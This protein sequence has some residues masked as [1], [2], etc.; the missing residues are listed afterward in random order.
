MQNMIGPELNIDGFGNFGREIF[1][2]AYAYER[3]YEVAD[4]LSLVRSGHTWRLGGLYQ[5]VQ[6]VTDT[7][8]YFG[9]RFNF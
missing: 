6:N 4:N 1:L 9:A 5:A 7:Q 8:T 2:P 3:R